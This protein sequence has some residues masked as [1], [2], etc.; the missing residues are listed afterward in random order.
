[1]NCWPNSATEFSSVQDIYM[2]GFDFLYLMVTNVSYNLTTKLLV[3]D[4][5]STDF[6]LDFR[7][8]YIIER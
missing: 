7:S 4:S 2:Q 8:L 3:L 6:H 5:F 1:M